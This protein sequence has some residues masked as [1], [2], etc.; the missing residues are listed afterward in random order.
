MHVLG[1]LPY[2]EINAAKFF[3]NIYFKNT[4]PKLQCRTG[5]IGCSPL[6]P[7]WKPGDGGVSVYI[8]CVGTGS[9]GVLHQYLVFIYVICSSSR[10]AS[11]NLVSYLSCTYELLLIYF[12]RIFRDF[13]VRLTLLK[14]YFSTAT[15]RYH[16]VEICKTFFRNSNPSF[17]AKEC[18]S[19]VH[20]QVVDGGNFG[21]STTRVSSTDQY[22]L[23]GG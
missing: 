4:N 22:L 7:W 13:S 21:W 16:H 20:N 23:D 6:C 12:F 17:A 8:C 5:T 19:L 9:T 1:V 11:I 14:N 10:Y 15:Q 18:I 2:V 3:N